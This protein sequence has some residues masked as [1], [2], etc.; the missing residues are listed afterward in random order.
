M[1]LT[2]I[3]SALRVH[4]ITHLRAKPERII[5]PKKLHRAMLDEVDQ[6]IMGPNAKSHQV[7]SQYDGMMFMSSLNLLE[8]RIQVALVDMPK[9]DTPKNIPGSMLG[10]HD[11]SE[12]EVDQ[13]GGSMV[14]GKN[15]WNSVTLKRVKK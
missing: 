13:V 10:L 7:A 5:L 4:C 11:D 1:K 8:D 9:V 3:F 2:Q 12:W 6:I 14:D 15:T